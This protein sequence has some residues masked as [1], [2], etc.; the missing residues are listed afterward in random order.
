MGV[1]AEGAAHRPASTLAGVALTAEEALVAADFLD[2]W[3]DEMEGPSEDQ[4][5]FAATLER[6]RAVVRSQELR[7]RRCWQR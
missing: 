4:I 6:L 5:R 3:A 1:L 2:Q 7:R